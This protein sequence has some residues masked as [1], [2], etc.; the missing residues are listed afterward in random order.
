MT[1]KPERG[2]ALVQLGVL[3]VGVRAGGEHFGCRG[4][5]QPYSLSQCD[6]CCVQADSSTQPL[7]GEA[8]SGCWLDYSF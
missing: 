2:Q 6:A 3:L 4:K 7:S 5:M 1:A 8:V